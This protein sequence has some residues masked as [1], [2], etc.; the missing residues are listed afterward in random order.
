MTS[1]SRELRRRHR[2]ILVWSLAA[3]AVIHVV[4]LLSVP[5]LHSEPVNAPPAHTTR[6]SNAKPAR[7]T[8]LGVIFGPTTIVLRDGTK[9]T[10]PADHVLRTH[11][12]VRL[13]GDCPVLSRPDTVLHGRV[14]L[15]V[16]SSGRATVVKLTESTGDPCGD[17]VLVDMAG[18]LWYGWLPDGRHPAPVD[19]SQ[20]VT[21]Y[22]V[23]ND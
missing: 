13:P 14:S 21:V 7:P 3:A 9:S 22:T 23:G 18:N 20:P 5:D 16:D 19:V 12:I 4:L 17:R 6:P 15:R 1:R 2:K 11:Q 8:I 10:E